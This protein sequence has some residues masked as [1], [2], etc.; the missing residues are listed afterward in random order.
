MLID[1]VW[2]MPSKHTFTIKPIRKLLVE[3]MVGHARWLDPFA[4]FNSPAFMTNDLNPAA[5]TLYHMDALEWLR[6]LNTGYDGV[7][8]DP[9]Y[10]MRQASECYMSYGRELLTATVTSM[11]YW[12]NVKNEIARLL[13]PGGK[14]VCFG[15]SSMGI[16][17]KRGFT[18]S[19]VLLVPHGGS[20]NDTIVTVEYK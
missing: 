6:S 17:I 20:R 18:M 1:R 13:R 5:P 12:S 16:G 10:S 19:R 7:I 2:A 4:G 9:P 15:W 14:A 11:A 8:Y 3:E